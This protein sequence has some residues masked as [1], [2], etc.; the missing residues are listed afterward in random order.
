L[1]NF[2]PPPDEHPLRGL[3][4]DALVDAG[5][6]PNID[7]D[8]DVAFVVNEQRLF[9]RCVDQPVG[10]LRVLGQ[11]RIGEDVEADELTQLRVASGVTLQNNLVKVGIHDEVLMVC[12]DHLVPQ[13]SNV[14][15]LTMICVG[16]VLNAVQAWHTGVGGETRGDSEGADSTGEDSSNGT[17]GDGG[18]QPPRSPTDG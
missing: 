17:A 18:V 10:A 5:L 16:A 15:E 11:W 9:A 2:P 4:L 13:G 1:P 8:G 12:V 3:V 6:E 7:D 14:G